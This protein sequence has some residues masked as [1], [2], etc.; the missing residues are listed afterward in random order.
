[1][2]YIYIKKYK[3]NMFFLYNKIYVN[4]DDLFV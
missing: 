1:M 4:F 3:Y 2:E